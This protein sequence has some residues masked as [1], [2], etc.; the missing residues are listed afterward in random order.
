MELSASNAVVVSTNNAAV[1]GYLGDDFDYS[2]E[3]AFKQLAKERSFELM[4]ELKT[5]FYNRII[6]RFI[7]VLNLDSRSLFELPKSTLLKVLK[8][9]V[10]LGEQEPYGVKG[11][12][13]VVNFGGAG[14]VVGEDDDEEVDANSLT[15]VGK[16]PLNSS[17]ISTFELELILFPST[18]FRH[19][20]ENLIRKL[21]GKSSKV[22]I[23][24]EFILKKKKLYR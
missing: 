15:N 8:G 11:G 6:P 4:E 18:A 7:K 10:T 24:D 16:F 5:S 23:R 21:K 1:E 19:K 14:M 3:N 22:V 12:T 9:M 17:V 13:L 2:M 20:L